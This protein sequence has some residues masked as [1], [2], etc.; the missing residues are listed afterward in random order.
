MALAVVAGL[1]WIV[2]WPI[3][4]IHALAARVFL[5]N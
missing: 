4:S 3:A 1:V 2:T 5:I